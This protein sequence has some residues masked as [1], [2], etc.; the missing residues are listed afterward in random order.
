MTDWEHK[1]LTECIRQDWTGLYGI[2]IRLLDKITREW[3]S[4]ADIMKSDWLSAS[5]HEQQLELVKKAIAN[6][7]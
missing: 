2:G 5:T 6:A 3:V 7:S 1:C 4:T